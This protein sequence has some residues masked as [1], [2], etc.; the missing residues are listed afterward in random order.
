M[1]TKCLFFRVFLMYDGSKA[2]DTVAYISVPDIS[3]VDV[4]SSDNL[5]K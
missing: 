4:S 5:K 2:N 3:E 1:H